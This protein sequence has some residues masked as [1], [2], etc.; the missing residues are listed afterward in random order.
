M[1]K[2]RERQRDREMIKEKEIQRERE[3]I[4]ERR[5]IK[6]ENFAEIG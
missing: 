6:C 4:K 3:M 2:E 1:I 5:E